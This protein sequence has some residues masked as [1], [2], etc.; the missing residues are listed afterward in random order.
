[1]SDILVRNVD[2]ALKK[3]LKARARANERSLSDEVKALVERGLAEAPI[4]LARSTPAKGVGTRLS[5][6][7]PPELWTDDFIVP[8]DKSGR[9][10]P[11]F[12]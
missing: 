10:P 9:E 8:R 4:S 11:D 2:P 12:S 3:R 5:E 6:L 7:I 1:M